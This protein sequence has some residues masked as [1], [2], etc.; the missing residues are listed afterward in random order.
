MNNYSSLDVST[1]ICTTGD[2]EEE[3]QL[4]I[5][6]VL[7]QSEPVGELIIVWDCHDIPKSFE[8]IH[9]QNTSIISVSTGSYR[10]GVSKARNLGISRSSC[11]LI[12]LLD[13]DD[14]W[15]PKKIDTQIEF[16]NSLTDENF[17]II[18]NALLVNENYDVI[19]K[20]GGEREGNSTLQ[21]Q[22]YFHNMP[23]RSAGI[24][25]PTSSF[26]FHKSLSNKI[27]FDE[28]MHSSEDLQFMLESVRNYPAF[29]ISSP[30]VLTKIRTL[31]K[32]GYSFTGFNLDHWSTWIS[33]NRLLTNRMRS[34]YH[35]YMGIK[36][37]LY[38]GKILNAMRLFVQKIFSGADAVTMLSSATLI[39]I[40]VAKSVFQTKNSFRLKIR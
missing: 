33:S 32:S 9:H 37:L 20:S 1:I 26:L 16:I 17:F 40:S 15:Y 2:R 28:T 7:L 25:I 35:L 18:S 5:E 4:S 27:F 21:L 6:S 34:N 12:A 23:L 8:N 38:E 14:Y 13:D 3:L 29:K 36:R 22:E 31:D 30:L 10:S 24:Y 19:R 11:S 39:L